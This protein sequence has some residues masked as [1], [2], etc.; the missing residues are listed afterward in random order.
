MNTGEP[1]EH[2]PKWILRV[3]DVGK[4][5][6]GKM[7]RECLLRTTSDNRCHRSDSLER[8]IDRL[9]LVRVICFVFFSFPSK[10]EGEVQWR[11][12]ESQARMWSQAKSRFGYHTRGCLP[13]W[14]R[15]AVFYNTLSV[16]AVGRKGK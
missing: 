1:G 9:T 8:E 11:T 7:H 14:H 10:E 5:G 12:G 15:G 4:A 16:F 6:E 2:E 3:L 13:L